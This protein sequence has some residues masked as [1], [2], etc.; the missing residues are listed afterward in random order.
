MQFSNGFRYALENNMDTYGD[1]YRTLR[2][3]AN[4]VSISNPDLKRQVD[5][6]YSHCYLPALSDYRRGVSDGNDGLVETSPDSI[7]EGPDVTWIGSSVFMS[8]YYAT[9]HMPYIVPGYPYDPNYDTEY[10]SDPGAGAPLCST[11]WAGTGEDGVEGIRDRIYNEAEEDGFLD[12]LKASAPFL[13]G[14]V[15]SIS[16]LNPDK[17][18]IARAYLEGEDRRPE[19]SQSANQMVTLREGD[20][21]VFERAARYVTS[22]GQAYQY[23]K[24]AAT[25]EL[26][27]D[28]LIY[29]LIV[30]QAYLLAIVYLSMPFALLLGRYSFSTLMGGAVL[31][32]SINFFSVL[33]TFVAFL[34]N[35]IA[36]QL[37]NG[38]GPFAALFNVDVEET[39]KR[40]VHA[41]VIGVLYLTST[42]GFGYVLLVG[43]SRLG[44][45]ISGAASG[46]AGG[47]SAAGGGALGGAAPSVRRVGRGG[48]GAARAYG[49]Y[50]SGR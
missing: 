45:S 18:E 39:Q 30:G 38:Q 11:Y 12:W 35:W 31:I 15:D 9:N 5:E 40:F 41:I 23:A 28:S 3:I 27:L 21:G 26:V 14:T 50:R 47:F 17:D 22:A 2:S 32:F 19:F 36:L 44:Y 43:G 25:M 42:M 8:G 20:A 6:F 37:W 1:S 46:G 48:F 10:A 29:A 49:K 16:F 24:Q 7:V 33:W 13:A 4:T 34:D